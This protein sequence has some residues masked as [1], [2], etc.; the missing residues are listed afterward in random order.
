MGRPKGSS[1]PIMER[2]RRRVRIAPSGCH[3]FTG[4]L[5]DGYG[6]VS[7]EKPGDSSQRVHVVVWVHYNGPIPKRKPRLCVLHKCDNRACCNRRHLFLGTR[8]EN[9]YDMI[10]KGRA[11]ISHK[12]EANAAAKLTTSKI[13][14]I[15][16]SKKINAELGRQYGVTKT[17]IGFIKKRKAW[18]HII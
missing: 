14:R 2:I 15:R 3:E 16:C 7:A 6:Y 8:A 11:K 17:M 4:C 10:A 18:R 5:A 1:T 9:T 13:R 12:G